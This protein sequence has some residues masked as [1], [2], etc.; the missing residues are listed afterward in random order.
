MTSFKYNRK[1]RLTEKCDEVFP[2]KPSNQQGNKNVTEVVLEPPSLTRTEYKYDKNSAESRERRYDKQGKLFYEH[3]FEYGKNGSL[4]SEKGKDAEGFYEINSWKYNDSG[5]LTEQ[6][7]DGFEKHVYEYNKKGELTIDL[8]FFPN[9]TEDGKTIFQAS[10]LKQTYEYD[11]YG[12][13]IKQSSYDDGKLQDL[14][15]RKIVYYK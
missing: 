13:W 15:K 8:T 14:I 9:V 2:A 10:G 7:V 12:N 1:G 4:I 6:I 11:T 3:V 5:I